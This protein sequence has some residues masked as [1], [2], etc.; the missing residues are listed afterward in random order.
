MKMILSM[1]FWFSCCCDHVDAQVILKEIILPRILR[2]NAFSAG[3]VHGSQFVIL[4]SILMAGELRQNIEVKGRS[5]V[6]VNDSLLI[7]RP[8]AMHLLASGQQ[9]FLS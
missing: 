3:V 9:V 1:R 6:V 5:V 2:F 8:L 4:P 7:G